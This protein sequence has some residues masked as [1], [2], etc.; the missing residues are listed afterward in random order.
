MTGASG[1]KMANFMYSQAPQDGTYIGIVQNTLI[2]AQAVGLPGV[3][4]DAEKFNWLGAIAPVVETMA[5]WHTT[6]V[7]D[8]RRRAQTRDRRRLH[9]ARR[10][11]LRLPGA[12]ERVPG[13]EV[14]D[15]LRLQRRQPDQHRDGARRGRG[16]QQFVVELEDHQAAMAHG[17]EDRRHRAG[18]SARGRPR[19]AVARGAGAHAGRTAHHRAGGLRHPVRPPVHDHA[20][21]AGGARA[22]RCAMPSR[23]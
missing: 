13:H 10:R 17:Q 5:V 1:L 8:D 21:H 3:Q 23:R 12:D 6:G 20:G 2:A 14:Q 19:R 11:H 4:F 16:A 18:G 22:R 7:T 9:R 15:R